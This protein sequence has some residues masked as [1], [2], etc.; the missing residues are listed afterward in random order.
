MI[1]FRRAVAL[2]LLPLLAVVFFVALFAG[3]VDATLLNP[4]FLLGHARDADLYRVVHDEGFPQYVDD[5]VEAQEERL[6]DNLRGANLPTDAEARERMTQVLQTLLPPEFM[7]SVVEGVLGEV[8]PYMAGREDG[9]EFSVSLYEPLKATFGHEPGERSAF[10]DAWLDLEFGERMIR[11]FASQTVEDAS[12]IAISPD[13]S[14]S[15]AAEALDEPGLRE[16][17]AQD[18]EGASTWWD[19][20]FFGVIDGILPYLLGD[21]E[22]F[23][24]RIDFSEYPHLAEAFAGP[25]KTDADTLR[26]QGWAFNDDE[27]RR[28]LAENDDLTEADIDNALAIFRPGGAT[29]DEVDLK[30]RI[31]EQRERAAAEGNPDDAPMDLEDQR[32]TLRTARLIATWGAAAA[33]V[34]LV[35][36]VAFLGG[37]GW[38]GRLRWGSAGV[39]VASLVSLVLTVPVYA[40]A[41]SGR[42]DDWLEEQR[43]REEGGLPELVRTHVLDEGRAVVQDFVGGMQWRALA[44]FV[45]AAL[46]FALA[47]ALDRP[48][49]RD[50]IRRA[51]A[52]VRGGSPDAQD[53]SPTA[54]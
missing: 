38:T 47:V 5:Y 52:R 45:L 9:F 23:D 4:D 13:A 22:E 26:R 8:V 36:A 19:E 51:I 18:I 6:P 20:Q 31:D 33:S 3:R 27:L 46:A 24:V 37:R 16:I 49:F 7:A 11:G 44:W 17:L 35:L 32:N 10:Q 50:T 28:R 25:L 15:E 34:L 48:D 42:V 14:A 54:P 39:L 29:F 40:V 21:S 2:L 41:V 43:T 1:I 12:G 53:A 30:E